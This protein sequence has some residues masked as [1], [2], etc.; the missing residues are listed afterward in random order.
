MSDEQA[1][2]KF[3]YEKYLGPAAL[4]GGAL[5]LGYATLS[6]GDAKANKKKSGK[7][8]ASCKHKDVEL[9]YGDLVE[10][11]IVQLPDGYIRWQTAF[12]PS[13]SDGNMLA[14]KDYC[15]DKRPYVGLVQTPTSDDYAIVAESDSAAGARESAMQFIEQYK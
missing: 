14:P 10:E 12:M 1:T 5:L 7:S 9:E 4:V 15:K 11:G 13:D 2:Q 8:E 6:S 3:E